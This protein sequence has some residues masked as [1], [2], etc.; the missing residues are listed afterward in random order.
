MQ[1][2]GHVGIALASSLA[3]WVNAAALALVLKRR[4]QLTIDDRLADRG[5]KIAL[6]SAGM[7]ASLFVGERLVASVCS[8]PCAA[9]IPALA[10]LIIGSMVLYGVLAHILGAVRWS[11]LKELRRGGGGEDAEGSLTAPK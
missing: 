3:A 8:G 2:W 10:I 6:A 1:V 4:G 5:P 7:A 11:D 9:N